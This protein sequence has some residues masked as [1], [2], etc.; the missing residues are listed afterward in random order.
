LLQLDSP[1]EVE[2][3]LLAAAPGAIALLERL[4]A[5]V[6]TGEEMTLELPVSIYGG[7]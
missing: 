5:E 7:G 6:P 4:E 2:R 1:A 3:R